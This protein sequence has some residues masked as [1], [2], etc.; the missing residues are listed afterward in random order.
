MA[1]LGYNRRRTFHAERFFA[2]VLAST[3][4]GVAPARA[5]LRDTM[6]DTWEATDGLGRSLPSGPS[7]GSPNQR[8]VLIFYYFWHQRTAGGGPYD[9][10]KI[11]AGKTQPFSDAPFGPSPAFHHWGEP[12]L[13]YYDINDEFVLRRHAQMLSDAGVDAIVL[14]V[15]NA[16][17]Y[18]ATWQKLCTV[19]A[20]LRAQGNRTPQISFIANSSSDAT[21]QHL[22]DVL[23]AKNA[24]AGLIYQYQG[25]PL[26]LAARGAALSAAAQAFFT[27]RQSWAW[28]DPNGWFGDGKDKWP[29]LDNY[30]Q[31][32]GWHD[33]AQVPE[34]MPVGVAQHPT[35]NYGRS[36]HAGKEPAL[37]ASYNTADTAQ[38]LGFQ[39]QWDHA[40]ATK[41]S[42]VFVTQWNEWIAQRFVKCGTYSTAA[43]EFL[44]KPL[45]CG[46]THFIDDFNEEFSRDIEPMRGGHEDAYYYQLVSNV[47][48]FKGARAV[49]NAS[50]PKRIEP[51]GAA[52]F[53][54]VGPDYL[55][56][57]GDVTHRNALGYAGPEVYTN[58][59]GRNDFE[60]L[61]VAR[62][63][64][65][66]YFYA[67]TQAPLSPSSNASWMTVWLDTD[68]G[69]KTG[70]GG[71]D[72]AVNRTRSGGTASVDRCMGST[73]ERVGDAAFVAAGSELVL[74]VPRTA[75]GLPASSGAL[76][77][78]FKWT[79]NVPEP[80][81]ALDLIELG[82]SAPNGRFTYRYTAGVDVDLNQ[83]DAG[84]AGDA[85]A[86]TADAASPS[87]PDATTG[88]GRPGTAQE[89]GDAESAGTVSRD[90]GGCSC[91][92]SRNGSIGA[93]TFL[94]FAF[95][96]VRRAGLPRFA[97]RRRARSAPRG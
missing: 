74:A 20:D 73:W 54:D 75:V 82:D 65:S 5:Q 52:A 94:G 29:W 16:A 25:K 59:T 55:D 49:P 40:I 4:L 28:S 24:C 57:V 62:D 92:S 78:R 90:A 84:N 19:Y 9:I 97:A 37:D 32:F 47:R 69:A 33:A 45:N 8:V 80:L 44:G 61:R 13:G 71:F 12:A 38:G 21:V 42:V 10:S 2:A 91:R 63:A 51:L 86:T 50:P 68:A 14:D 85:A 22:Y 41:P 64:S 67:K 60:V 7:V 39:E 56:D 77:F 87:A 26:I 18:D 76:S 53:A 43:T 48:R 72:Y 23:Y 1:R 66:L 93:W 79:D 6:S 27:F 46:D 58:D 11:I 83:A 89:A 35:S 70:C 95:A 17:T 34:E 30:P 88:G 15:T 31:N 3:V 81:Q 96:C 36:H